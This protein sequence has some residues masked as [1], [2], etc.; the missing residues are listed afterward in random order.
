MRKTEETKQAIVELR[1]SGMLAKDIAEK[2]NIK[3]AYVYN[4]CSQNGLLLDSSQRGENRALLSRETKH[5]IFEHIRNGATYKEVGS[6]MSIDAETVRN[7]CMVN[8][9]KLTPAARTRSMIDLS[10]AQFEEIKSMRL[11]GVKLKVIAQKFG[12][13]KKNLSWLANKYGWSLTEEQKHA[14]AKWEVGRKAV[15][16]FGVRKKTAPRASRFSWLDIESLASKLKLTVLEA[17]V[18]EAVVGSKTARATL[19]L[20]CHCSAVFEVVFVDFMYNRYLSCGCSKSK[21][22]RDIADWIESLG[23]KIEFNNRTVI[24]PL[25]LDIYVPS[26]NLAIEYCGLHWH[27]EGILGINARTKHIQKL[28]MCQAAGIRLITIFSDEW[29]TKET[30][31]RGYLQAVLGLKSIVIGA[32][33]CTVKEVSGD[34]VKDFVNTNHVFGFAKSSGYYVLEKDGTILAALTVLARNNWTEI[35]RFAVKIG[36]SVPGGFSKMLNAV[37]AQYQG[38]LRTF[39]DLR[40][41]E[42]NLY[43]KAGFTLKHISTPTPWNTKS[44]RDD[45]RINRFVLNKKELKRRLGGLFLNETQWQAVR[46][47]GY[48]RIWDCGKQLWSLSP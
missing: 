2:L 9:V 33:K 31:V 8:K 13:D 32:R 14:N 3:K 41:S 38:E 39:A 47:L 40:W 34:C 28:K 27:S 35:N 15:P 44:G 22:Q 17:F 20:R 7:V 30:V 29:L 43:K 25:E 1:K 4:F 21:P 5:K 45:L 46:R 37:K 6:L 16:C 12:L 19:T 48:D 42:G 18:Y 24:K 10:E 26:K 23:F 36:V 11:N